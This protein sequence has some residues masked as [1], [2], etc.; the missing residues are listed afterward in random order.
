[1]QERSEQLLTYLYWCLWSIISKEL[2]LAVF[3]KSC[4]KNSVQLWFSAQL[5]CCSKLASKHSAQLSCCLKVVTFV[6]KLKLVQNTV[7]N[8]PVAR[9]WRQNTLR[10]CRFAWN[11]RLLLKSL[12]LLKTACA[13]VNLVKWA[14]LVRNVQ[15]SS[16]SP[17]LFKFSS[18]FLLGQK[19]A[20][21]FKV[22]IF[23]QKSVRIN[24]LLE[25]SPFFKNRKLCRTECASG[26]LRK[27]RCA[28]K[29]RA[30]FNYLY[31]CVWSII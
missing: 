11:W 1:M 28:R 7:H 19:R 26:D 30:T 16:N 31:W 14:C 9:N 22:T 21:I 24:E 18:I 15:T 23:V 10:K 8:C 5:S 13:T 12:K 3:E 6:K 27:L 29:E 25:I 17:L 20:D 4:G 2:R